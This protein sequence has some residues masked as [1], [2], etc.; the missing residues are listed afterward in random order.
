MQKQKEGFSGERTIIL[1]Q[2][3]VERSQKD[4]LLSSL[5]ITDIGYYPNAYNHYRE[6]KTPISE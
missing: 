4:P 6:R 2:I 5:Y 3:I 1:P